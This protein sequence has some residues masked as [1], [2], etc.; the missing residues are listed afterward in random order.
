MSVPQIGNVTVRAV[1]ERS[2]RT[3]DTIFLSPPAD[4]CHVFDNDGLRMAR[5]RLQ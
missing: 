2:Y 4:K 1:G 3:G 5:S